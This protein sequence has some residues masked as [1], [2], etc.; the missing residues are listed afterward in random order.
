MDSG[1]KVE[2]LCRKDS[3][4]LF[5]PSLRFVFLTMLITRKRVDKILSQVPEGR[6]KG[7]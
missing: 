1:E 5:L 2:Y 6:N 7:R 4:T 3:K